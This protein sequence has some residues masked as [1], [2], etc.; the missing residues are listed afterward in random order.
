MERE[1][2]F[3]DFSVVPHIC[4]RISSSEEYLLPRAWL[5]PYLYLYP[6]CSLVGRLLLFSTVHK[7]RHTLEGGVTIEELPLAARPVGVSAGHFLNAN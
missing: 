2:V 7:R 1:A 3:H 4:L 6:C 5:N